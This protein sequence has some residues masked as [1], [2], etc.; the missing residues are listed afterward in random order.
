LTEQ[1]KLLSEYPLERGVVSPCSNEADAVAQAN[2]ARADPTRP[3]RGFLKVEREM[4][5]SPSAASVARRVDYATGS[6]HSTDDLGCSC[7]C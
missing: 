1:V 4:R 3:P 5:R 7:H 2:G 6:A